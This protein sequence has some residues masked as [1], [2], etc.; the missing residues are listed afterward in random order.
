MNSRKNLN[1]AKIYFKSHSGRK[2]DTDGGGAC[3]VL[4]LLI[5]IVTETAFLRQWK[6]S[7]SGLIARET[8]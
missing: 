6:P 7:M 3:L 8:A 1:Y 5:Q 2:H 4:C